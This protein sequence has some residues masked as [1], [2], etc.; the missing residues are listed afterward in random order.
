MSFIRYYTTKTPRFLQTI[1][2]SSKPA[3]TKP[4]VV[5]RP[6]GLPVPVLL[7][8]KE[9][10]KF[11]IKNEIFSSEA[12]EIRQKQLDHDI[13]HSPFYESKS[14]TNTNG[15]IFTPPISYFK[16]DKSL[17]FPNFFAK[18]LI[19]NEHQLYELLQDKVSI[20]RVFSTVSGER[21]TE[22]YLKQDGIDFNGKDYDKFLELYP[23]SQI[24]DLNIP[25]GWAKRFMV[26]IA[27]GNIK[28]T[29]SPKRYDSYFVVNDSLFSYYIK[30]QLICD[31]SCSGYIYLVDNNGKV[32]WGTSGYA[33]D[34]EKSLLYKCLL[35]IS[36]EL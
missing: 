16:S 31:N 28:K 26:N 19:G 10:G 5:N 21:C 18:S 32:R 14:F 35:G 29:L 6:F 2:E 24:I 17:Y 36:K 30:E 3:L 1:N 12:K 34:K 11:S 27:K 15:K 33:D 25:Q 22:T 7:N 9:H 13:K 8:P 20:I 4:Q 23:K